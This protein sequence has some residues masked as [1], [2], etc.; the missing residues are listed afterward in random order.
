M[1][2]IGHTAYGYLVELSPG[3]LSHIT[4]DPKDNQHTSRNSPY[5]GKHENSHSIGTTFNVSPTWDHLP[6][7]LTNE[8]HRQRI[9]ESL[10]AAAT[11]IEHTP[12]PIQPASAEVAQA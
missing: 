6:K 3:E 4:G 12:S 11:L 10:R 7:L 5:G 8:P 1:K 9:A 2:I